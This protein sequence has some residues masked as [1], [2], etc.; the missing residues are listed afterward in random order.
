MRIL[1]PDPRSSD[2]EIPRRQVPS[3]VSLTCPAD[4]PGIR[5]SLRPVDLGVT[6]PCSGMFYLPAQ[7]TSLLTQVT[8]PFTKRDTHINLLEHIYI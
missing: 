5:S 6:H 3:N 8:H 1:G 2:S 7:I 4:D